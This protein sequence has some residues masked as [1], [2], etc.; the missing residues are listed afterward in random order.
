[1]D[2]GRNAGGGALAR[3]VDEGRELA[4]VS[5]VRLLTPRFL[6]PFLLRVIWLL[7]LEA[8]K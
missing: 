8:D 3:D 1:M 2:S 5:Q 4:D 7:V 6:S